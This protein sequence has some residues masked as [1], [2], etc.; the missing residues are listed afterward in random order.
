[1]KTYSST[2]A[3]EQLKSINCNICGSNSFKPYL[4]LKDFSYK[5]CRVCGLVFQNPQP[6]FHDL[7]NRYGEKYFQYEFTNE[8]NFFK[9][10]LLGLKDIGFN[11]SVLTN[12]QD[13]TFLDIGCAT[14]R[15]LFY[16]KQRNWKVQGVEICDESVQYGR[17]RRHVPIFKGTLEQARYKDKSFSLIHFSH[18]I[19]HVTDPRSFLLEVR[20]VLKSKGFAVITTPNICGF[21]ARLFK[22]K[23]RSAIGDHLFLFS[24]KTLKRLLQQTGFKVHKVVTWGGLA[25]GTAPSWIKKPVDKLA[26]RWGFG[27]VMLFLVSK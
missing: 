27:D 5:K 13:K 19:E 22:T 18:L 25:L 1:M 11:H 10:M 7:K 20:R 17:T 15:L 3:T 21:Q 26:K 12:W 14:G 8:E 16:F 2:P 4:K 6:I 24:K 23:W 9:L